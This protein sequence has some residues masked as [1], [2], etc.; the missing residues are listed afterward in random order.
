[1]NILKETE[2]RKPIAGK[3]TKEI[4]VN[5]KLTQNDGFK[6]LEIVKNKN[7]E[8][9]LKSTRTICDIFTRDTMQ[10]MFEILK[11]NNPKHWDYQNTFSMCETRRHTKYFP[12]LEK[13]IGG[14]QR[15]MQTQ[16]YRGRELL[17][18]IV[19]H[20]PDQWNKEE[21]FS[22]YCECSEAMKLKQF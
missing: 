4:S 13:A 21:S 20:Q 15:A 17:V 19:K 9:G 3:G 6:T 7:E 12:T 5:V 16:D 10:E 8:H 14:V 2:T 18:V 11:R 22:V 1:M